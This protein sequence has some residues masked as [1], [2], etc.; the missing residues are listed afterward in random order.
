MSDDEI[1]AAFVPEGITEQA[2]IESVLRD[3]GIPYLMRNLGV[4]NLLGVGEIGGFN[5]VT[6]PVEILL[7]QQ[8]L[9]RAS[10]LVEAAF[11]EYTESEVEELR[12][13]P[14]P[15]KPQAETAA[16]RDSKFSLLFALIGIGGLGS[17]LGIYL[18]LRSLDS[19]E[20]APPRTKTKARLGIVVGALG[21]VLYGFLLWILL[22]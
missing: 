12:E 15:E 6:G 7:R 19:L 2:C 4:Q 9:G 8:D 5:Q 18:G 22:H 16:E 11:E 20:N 17:V 14:E 1:V 10:D 13:P 3:A 21:L